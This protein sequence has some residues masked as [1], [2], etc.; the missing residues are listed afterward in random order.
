M[1]KIKVKRMKCRYNRRGLMRVSTVC[2][3]GGKYIVVETVQS[4]LLSH[5]FSIEMMCLQ[6]ASS[7]AYA[8]FRKK[9][10]LDQKCN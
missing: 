9:K 10:K 7:Q 4:A 2:S 6:L 3:I 1:I 8:S 5:R